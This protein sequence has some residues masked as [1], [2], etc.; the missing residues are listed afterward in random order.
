MAET[1]DQKTKG[2]D[3]IS[4][5]DLVG[6]V[7]TTT[8]SPAELALSAAEDHPPTPSAGTVV[9]P[10]DKIE[11]IDNLLK[12]EDPAFAGQME[13]LHA[14]GVAAAAEAAEIDPHDLE[15]LPPEKEVGR[16]RKVLRKMSIWPALAIDALQAGAVAAVHALKALGKWLVHALKTGLANFKAL[17]KVGKIKVLGVVILAGLAIAALNFALHSAFQPNLGPP[18][19][20]S[21]ATLADASFTYDLKETLDD[22]SDPM[23]HPEH[24]VVFDHLVVNLRHRADDETENPMGLF[25]FYFSCSSQEGAVEL[26]DREAEARDVISRALET[27]AYQEL[28]TGSGKEKLK[29]VLRKSLNGFLTKGQ[30]RR[31]FIKN[32]VL[33][34]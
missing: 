24:V 29:T 3:V 34:N 7:A 31:V 33:K 20:R 13:E 19:V 14:Q 23:L 30:V 11:A 18:F 6:A 26:K 16:V 2:D 5:E 12:V 32:M 9:E 27:L 28:A 17:S 15:H 22:F 8:A 4:L 25:A 21:F 10:G 1:D